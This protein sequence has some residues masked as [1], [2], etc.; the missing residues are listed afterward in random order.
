MNSNAL[1][2]KNGHIIEQSICN[3]LG[4]DHHPGEIVDTYLNGKPLEIK[5]C[6]EWIGDSSHTNCR[7][8]GRFQFNE[9]QHRYLVENNGI[10]AFVVQVDGE[11]K[12]TCFRKASLIGAQARVVWGD[13]LKVEARDVYVTPFAVMK[14][15]LN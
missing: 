11:I 3:Y 4:L 9:E 1:A 7:R 8:S 13:S 5:S 6:Q 10:Y 15:W 12:R 2:S 14:G